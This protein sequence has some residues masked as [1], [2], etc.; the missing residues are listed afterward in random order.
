MDPKINNFA[1]V[2]V[3]PIRQICLAADKQVGSFYYT[4]SLSYQ[5]VRT[6]AHVTTVVHIRSL[7][8][9]RGQ[10]IIV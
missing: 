3:D 4:D 1:N 5:V 9:P 10:L 2:T 7:S 6:I 8:D